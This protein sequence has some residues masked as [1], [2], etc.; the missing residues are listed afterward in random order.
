M[1]QGEEHYFL[2]KTN[3]PCLVSS[4]AHRLA[5]M[6]QG[7]TLFNMAGKTFEEMT[8]ALKKGDTKFQTRGFQAI[9]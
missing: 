7:S 8:S 6:G 3:L 9:N 1:A 4:D 5:E 2:D